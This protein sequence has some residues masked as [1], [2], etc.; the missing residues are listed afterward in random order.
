[1]KF[2]KLLLLAFLITCFSCKKNDDV[3]IIDDV[4][5][6]GLIDMNE[7]DA[8]FILNYGNAITRDIMVAVVD[9]NGN[10]IEDVTISVADQNKSTDN[11]GIA[12]LNNASVYERFGYIK[13]SKTGF[14]H[15]SRSIAPT[16][17][18]NQVRIMML[19]EIV[20][21]ST[22]SGEVATISNGSGASVLLNGNYVDASGA[23]YD[24]NVDVI[25]HHLDPVDENMPD[26]MPGMLYAQD[27]DGEEQG[28]VTLGMLAVELRGANGEDLNL[29]E[30]STATITVPVD[31]SLIANA[32]ATIPLWYFDEVNGVWIEEGQAVLDGN[33]YVGEVSHFSFWNCDIPTEAY[34]VCFNIVDG[35]NNPLSGLNLTVT[36]T[37]FGTNSGVT[38][39]NGQVC[40]FIPAN[41]VLTLNAYVSICGD[42]P[43]FT[44]T[45]GPITADTTLDFVIDVAGDPQVTTEEI[46][47]IFTDCDNN[48]VTNGYVIINYNNAAYFVAVENGNFELDFIRCND[49]TTFTVLGVDS[50]TAETTELLEYTFNT[51]STDIGTISSCVQLVEYYAFTIDDLPQRLFVEGLGFDYGPPELYFNT[52]NNQQNNALSI[53]LPT[54]VEGTYSLT[55]TG[56]FMYVSDETGLF[57]KAGFNN[58]VID[59]ELENFGEVGEMID[60][61]FSGTFEEQDGTPHT[62]VG[63][64]HLIR[65]F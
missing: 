20:S 17:G 30:G 43:V 28:L 11:N 62:I 24:G 53:E 55:D 44:T 63:E 2:T 39:P 49:D 42:D 31:A 13:A 16:V 12:I 8:N 51:P 26:Q 46:T 47:G 37:V 32:P 7:F 34:N 23:A 25:L 52:F 33:A 21:G 10:P 56:V 3:D 61:S 29:M 57:I 54:D 4:D 45:F 60:L 22:N 41:E 15:A 27:A 6:V 36:S 65:P 38:N 35:D 5:D 59:I 64:I 18:T 9:I 48:P 1:M 40:G 50:N 58:E 19:P 14:I